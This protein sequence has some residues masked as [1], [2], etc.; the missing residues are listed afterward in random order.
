MGWYPLEVCIEGGG[1]ATLTLGLPQVCP[2][3]DRNSKASAW[4]HNFLLDT[5]FLDRLGEMG[6]IS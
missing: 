5:V 6:L 2:L 4:V 1:S 3:L